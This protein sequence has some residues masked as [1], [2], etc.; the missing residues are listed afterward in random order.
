[1]LRYE[2]H[3]KAQSICLVEEEIPRFLSAAH[4]DHGHYAAQLCL[5]FLVGWAYWPT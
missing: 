3:N 5:S 4:K 1:M 2:E